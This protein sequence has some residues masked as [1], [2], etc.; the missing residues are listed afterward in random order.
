MRLTIYDID[1]DA[2]AAIVVTFQGCLQSP[3][4]NPTG[5]FHLFFLISLVVNPLNRT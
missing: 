5:N 2:G 4:H 1:A 3:Q